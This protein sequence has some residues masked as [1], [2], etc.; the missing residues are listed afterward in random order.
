MFK[1]K[2]YIILAVFA[3]LFSCSKNEEEAIVGSENPAG[4]VSSLYDALAQGTGLY[5]DRI[6]EFYDEKGTVIL[7][8]FPQDELNYRG[9]SYYYKDLLYYTYAEEE[10]VEYLLD[11][12]I[13]MASPW[14]DYWESILFPRNVYIV[15]TLYT[16]TEGTGTKTNYA[17]YNTGVSYI[18]AG[19]SEANSETFLSDKPYITDEEIETL[20]AMTSYYVG[21]RSRVLMRYN[22]L[23]DNFRSKHTGGY[24]SPPDEFVDIVSQEIDI[25]VFNALSSA[26][27]KQDYLT[28]LG[29]LNVTCS[30]F[31][32]IG[33]YYSAERTGTSYTDT[34]KLLSGTPLE[35][36]LQTFI[37]TQFYLYYYNLFKYGYD[38][39]MNTVKFSYPR[40]YAIE[41]PKEV[42][43]MLVDKS[44]EYAYVDFAELLTEKALVV[45]ADGIDLD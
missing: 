10:Y 38:Y 11:F 21:I 24:I 16:V 6:Q 18:L 9:G 12:Y 15:D 8:E 28:S 23:Y 7:Y 37:D 29:I 41:K 31:G 36:N 45:T 1:N 4:T 27:D 42:M 33:S 19:A 20:A 40:I 3:V 44:P 26:T 25:D 14:G 5:A 35:D 32:N 2:I 17:A 13:Q 39:F 34:Y 43:Q 30:Y 22:L